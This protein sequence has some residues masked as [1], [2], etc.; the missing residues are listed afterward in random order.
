M[1]SKTYQ[2]AVN[3]IERLLGDHKLSREEILCVLAKVTTNA[4]HVIEERPLRVMVELEYIKA[5]GRFSAEE[6]QK[7]LHLKGETPKHHDVFI[8][9]M[10]REIDA[11][12]TVEW[13]T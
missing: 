1:D 2:Y 11:Y 6:E 3:G 13:D 5:L 4:I 12:L 10:V 7:Q 9:E 8:T